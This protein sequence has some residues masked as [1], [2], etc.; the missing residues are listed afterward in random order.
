MNMKKNILLFLLVL[1]TLNSYSQWIQKNDLPNEYQ[2]RNHP[3]TFAIDD[4][5]YVLTGGREG[6]NLLADFYKYDA[7]MDSWEQLP[8]FPGGARSYS[9]GLTYDEMG[10]VGFGVGT[11]GYFN[12]L[13]KFDPAS[14][15]WTALSDC[16]CIGRAHPA[17]VAANNKIYVG[18]G[19]NNGNLKDWWEYDIATD[20][21]NQ[22]TD[23]PALERHHPYY[24]SIGDMVYAGFGHG[25]SIFKDLYEYNAA[26]NSWTQMADL[27][28]QGRV[29]GSQFSFNGKGYIISGE[30]DDHGHLPEGEFWEY[31]PQS[32]SW[33]QLPSHPGEGRWAPGTFIIDG[34]LYLTS[35]GVSS[36]PFNE[37]DLWEF[38]LSILF[39]NNDNVVAPMVAFY[40]NPSNGSLNFNTSLNI[41]QVSIWDFNG[42]LVQEIKDVTNR[43]DLNQLDAGMYIIGI[44]TQEGN[45]FFEKLILE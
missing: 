30:G 26:S 22:K 40:P 38:D 29:A 41:K 36:A 39:S 34:K 33:A 4:T 43:I 42:R 5:G 45:Y 7:T 10:Y 1:W 13:W 19:S 21:W 17:F 14:E 16:P 27:P 31:D 28:A 35:G 15:T 8:D 2:G 20:S 12:D 6:G 25:S 3:V 44:E 9:Y 23:F 32:N 37:K 11:E 24:F 18:L